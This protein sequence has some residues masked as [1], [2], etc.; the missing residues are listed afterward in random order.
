MSGHRPIDIVGGGLAGLSLALA[1]RRH[2]VP[3]AVWEAGDYPRHRVC[4][5]FIT[6]LHES[7][8]VRLGLA[9][10]LEGALRHRQVGW[11]FNDRPARVYALSADALGLSRYTLDARLAAAFVEAGGT[12][13]TRTRIT[14]QLAQPGRVVATGRPR[15]PSPWIGLKVHVR[16]IELHCDLELHLGDDAY[17]GL[18]PVEDGSINVCGL[19]R[20]RPPP[21]RSADVLLSYLHA[22]GLRTLAARVAG[23]DRCE[24]SFCAMAALDFDAAVPRD[25]LVVRLGDA[26]ATIPPFTGNGMAMAFQSAETALDPLL[27]Y[28]RGEAGW[29]ETARATNV[30][31]RRRFRLRLASADAL[32]SFMLRPRRQRWL[33][34]LSRTNFVPLRLLYAVLH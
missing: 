1:L 13:R 25:E 33:A 4:G 8:I 9:P 32:H 14:G 22:A 26:C 21:G 30:A 15:R 2:G 6:G 31:L 24:G 20:Q 18:A 27:A 28:A 12:L 11:Y 29:D 23:S 34:A 10:V 7:T 17:V 16:R 19:F 3:V 5:E